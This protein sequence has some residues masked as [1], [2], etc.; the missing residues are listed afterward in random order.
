M[1]RPN[2]LLRDKKGLLTI[3][4]NAMQMTKE[5]AVVCFNVGIQSHKVSQKTILERKPSSADLPLRSENVNGAAFPRINSSGSYRRMPTPSTDRDSLKQKDSM[6][7]TRG[8]DLTLFVQRW[9]KET[10]GYGLMMPEKKPLRPVKGL[11]ITQS[12]SGGKIAGVT[13]CPQIFNKPVSNKLPAIAHIHREQ[14]LSV[15]GSNVE[16]V[17]FSSPS[18]MKAKFWRPIGPIVKPK[19]IISSPVPRPETPAVTIN[20]S[21][22]GSSNN[23]TLQHD[24]SSQTV[25]TEIDTKIVNTFFITQTAE[26]LENKIV[27]GEEEEEE[28][29]EIETWQEQEHRQVGNGEPGALLS[30]RIKSRN[31]RSPTPQPLAVE[32]QA[33]TNVSEETVPSSEVKSKKRRNR[34]GKHKNKKSTKNEVKPIMQEEVEEPAETAP[35]IFIIK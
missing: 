5:K 9:Q 2:K 23:S 18:R 17:S 33:D 34:N 16:K 11:A 13:N 7:M 12:S 19:G 28:K 10:A 24:E 31:S 8:G 6:W 21:S 27:L 1:D 25:E 26:P 32:S 3:D 30:V 14:D 29:K 20:W 22:R 15:T 35:D 4:T